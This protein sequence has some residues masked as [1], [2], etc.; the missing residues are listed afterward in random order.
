VKE[1][2]QKGAFAQ[3]ELHSRFMDSKCPDKGNVCEFLDELCVEKEKLAT[4]GVVIEDK[5]YHSTIITSL[6]PHLS[7]FASS[8]LVNVRLHA[9]LKTVD[10]DELILLIS[11][12]YDRGVS[13]CLRRLGYDMG[14]GKPVIMWSQVCSGMGTGSGLPYP[15]NTVPFSTVLRVCWYRISVR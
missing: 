14:M 6:P 2:T 9:A 13:Q 4:Y 11:E 8:I 1:Y 7:N 12:E 5:D 3:A 15:G 10:P